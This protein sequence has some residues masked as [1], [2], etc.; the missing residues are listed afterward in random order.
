MGEKMKHWK[1]IG[2]GIRKITTRLKRKQ[3]NKCE[4][5]QA[6][7]MRE[8]NKEINKGTRRELGFSKIGK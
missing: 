8:M 2:K 7:L 6:K 5:E 4:K 3:G 1:E